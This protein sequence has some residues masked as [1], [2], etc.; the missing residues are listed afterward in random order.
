MPQI[1]YLAK[2]TYINVPAIVVAKKTRTQDLGIAIAIVSRRQHYTNSRPG[3]AKCIYA[4]L[5]EK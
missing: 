5:Y 4:Y 2:D 1:S 3:I